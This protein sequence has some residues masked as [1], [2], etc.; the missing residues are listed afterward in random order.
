MFK[1]L[2]SQIRMHL[3]SLFTGWIY[4]RNPHLDFPLDFEDYG[5]RF[6]AA[7]VLSYALSGLA[8][9][10]ALAFSP[11]LSIKTCLHCDRS[12]LAEMFVTAS[13]AVA[14]F[15]AVIIASIPKG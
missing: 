6:L 5:V 2:L 11:N 15:M 13:C 14:L 12:V 8:M 3:P 4:A 9:L 10:L 1:T 7:L